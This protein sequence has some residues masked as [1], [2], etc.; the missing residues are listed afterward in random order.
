MLRKA[1][2]LR[3]VAAF[4]IHW[5][6]VRVLDG[7]PNDSENLGRTGGGISAAWPAPVSTLVSRITNVTVLRTPARIPCASRW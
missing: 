7:P 2:S 5:L 6:Q 1:A 4:L 3:Q